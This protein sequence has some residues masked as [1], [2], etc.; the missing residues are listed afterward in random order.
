M[1]SPRATPVTTLRPAPTPALGPARAATALRRLPATG[2]AVADPQ[3][4]VELTDI[5]SRGGG[6]A[7]TGAGLSTD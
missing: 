2:P 1:T 4:L 7:L 5:V 3:S 6:P